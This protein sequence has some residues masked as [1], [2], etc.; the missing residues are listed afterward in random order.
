VEAAG[1]G[2]EYENIVILAWRYLLF[3]ISFLASIL[4]VF[5]KRGG[6]NSLRRGG[7]QTERI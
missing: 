7:N 1:T 5:T 3:I 2:I 6:D 4:L